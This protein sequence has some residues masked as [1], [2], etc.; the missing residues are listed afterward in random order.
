MLFA[1]TSGTMK[2]TQ[3]DTTPTGGMAV[4]VSDLNI[5]AFTNSGALISGGTCYTLASGTL[6][7]SPYITNP[8]GG[9][10]M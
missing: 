8:D 2:V 3:A 7:S 6:S 10:D 4:T 5:A 1:P 9:T